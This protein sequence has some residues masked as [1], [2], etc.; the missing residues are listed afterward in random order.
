MSFEKFEDI[1]AWK[2][3]ELLTLGIYRSLSNCRDYGFKDQIQRATVS[4]MNNI[5]EGFE[6]RGDREFRRFLFISKGSCAEVRPMIY[7][8]HDLGYLSKESCR[9]YYDLTLEI[10][11]MLSGLI[12]TL[13]Y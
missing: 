2:K 7:L 9:E 12:K 5:A 11:K 10:S 3:A 6:R 1:I 4:I 8:C 13:K